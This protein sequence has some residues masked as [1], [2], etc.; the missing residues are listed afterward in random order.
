LVT[1][2]WRA[3]LAWPLA[4]ALWRLVVVEQ[5]VVAMEVAL[6]YCN[7]QAKLL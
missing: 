7:L 4:Q 3:L 2:A 5:V 6:G 1:G